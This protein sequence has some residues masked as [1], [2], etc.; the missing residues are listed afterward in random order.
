MNLVLLDINLMDH[1]RI[2]FMVGV[3]QEKSSW[4]IHFIIFLY[5]QIH[6]FFYVLSS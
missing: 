5:P 6:F 4:A 3:S 2:K 1:L